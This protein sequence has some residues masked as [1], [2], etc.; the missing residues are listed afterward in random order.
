MRAHVLQNYLLFL[1]VHNS[2]FLQ[3]LIKNYCIRPHFD[4]VYSAEWVK[5]TVICNLKP[6]E[7]QSTYPELE[8]LH[9]EGKQLSSAIAQWIVVAA[10][11]SKNL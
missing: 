1:L 8:Y 5:S 7:L 9:R 6:A 10:F 4:V 2:E 11:T 3:N